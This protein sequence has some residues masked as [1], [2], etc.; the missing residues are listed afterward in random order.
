MI[1]K[2]PL[3]ENYPYRDDEVKNKLW[4]IFVFYLILISL[5]L[6]VFILGFTDKDEKLFYVGLGVFAL[7]VGFVC[8]LL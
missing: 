1:E 7:P 2:Q 6:Y 5:A 8:A 4:I 3:F